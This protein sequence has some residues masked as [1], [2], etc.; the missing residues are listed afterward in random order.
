MNI[1]VWGGAGFLGSHICDALSA[2]GHKV[3]IADINHSTWKKDNQEMIIGSVLDESI[4]NE[5]IKNA[6]YV[7]NFSGIAD[8]Q[9]ANNDPVKSSKINILGNLN[10]M[11]ACVQQNI[12]RYIF[13]SSLYVYSNSG[14]FYRCTK[15][16]CENFIAEYQRQYNL[17][18]TI[19][20]FG[21]LYGLRSNDKNAIYRFIE[22]A[23]LNKKISYFGSQN[24]LREYIHV[25]DAAKICCD[26][27]DKDKEY[28]NEY[29]TITG[30]QSMRVGD[31][32]KMIKAII[33][34]DIK[35][36][37]NTNVAG[38]HYE[39]TP[40]NFTPKLGRKYSPELHIDLGQ[41][42]LQIMELIQNQIKDKQ[43]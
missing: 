25:E 38:A 8:I 2:V 27:L 39:I 36:E 17:D 10:L 19:L 40:Y 18:F 31:L 24:A 15:Q 13:A 3:M 43:K 35:I 34:E 21:S 29:I 1:T 20:R 22:Q 16:S 41:G 12:K 33:G 6:D 11:N 5:S 14:G 4:V 28:L 7:F 37:Y 30:H 9:E 32:L 26:I 23:L 42:L